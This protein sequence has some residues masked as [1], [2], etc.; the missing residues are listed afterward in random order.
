MRVFGIGGG[1]EQTEFGDG[2]DGG[3][4]LAAEAHGF[5]RF[6][7]VQAADLAGGVTLDR[8]WQLRGRD[9]DAVIL[10][11]D[12]ADAASLQSHGDVARA[13]IEGI[14]EQFTHDGSRTLDDFTSGDLADQFIGQGLDGRVGDSRHGGQKRYR[15]IVASLCREGGML[16]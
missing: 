5:D 7:I 2:T 14:V 11:R 16:R 4:G 9:A 15:G 6:E 13:G 12:Q 3:Q 1:G 10:D 8:Q